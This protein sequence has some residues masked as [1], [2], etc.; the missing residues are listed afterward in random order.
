LRGISHGNA[1]VSKAQKI[2]EIDPSHLEQIYGIGERP[3]KIAQG[4][5]K[6]LHTR[7]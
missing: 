4:I 7:K 1:Q 6:A 3:M 2:I 5:I